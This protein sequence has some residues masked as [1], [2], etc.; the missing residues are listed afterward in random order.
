MGLERNL[1]QAKRIVVKV[2]TSSLTHA[3]GLFNLQAIDQLS[4]TLSGLV[5]EGKEI[6]L[7]SS[8][9]IGVGM[10][11]LRLT[12]RP[13][14]IP[15]QQALAAIGQ[16]QLMAVY[17][18]RFSLYGQ[19]ISQVLLTHDVLDYPHSR[20]NVLNT[21]DTLL[22]WG[23]IPIVNENDTVAV[24]E[25]DHI[26]KFGD[27]DQLSA[28]V[29]TAINADLLVM[30]S[31]IAG[32]YNKNPQKYS[33]AQLITEITEINEQTYQ[34]AEGS[35]TNLGTG[36]MTTKLKAAEMMLAANK[37]MIL[38]DGSNP[39]IIFKILNNAAIGTL[40]DKK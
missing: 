4:Y 5:N 24:A 12:Q 13:Q 27:N 10:G 22:S 6:V 2:G 20:A 34:A 26:T 11:Q 31:D 8:G 36:G 14:S 3:N 28:I 25:L 38:A 33:D 23:V 30:L 35:G 17:Q 15:E 9:A 32:F 21:F 18:Q 29:A 39:S 16:S 37:K 7:V 40:F 19:K 1:Q